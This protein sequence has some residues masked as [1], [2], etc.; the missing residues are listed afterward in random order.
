MGCCVRRLHWRGRE[1][2]DGGGRGV[3]GFGDA[4]GI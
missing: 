3:D 2:A 4:A 1:L